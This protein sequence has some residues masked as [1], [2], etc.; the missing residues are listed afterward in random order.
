MAEVSDQVEFW[1]QKVMTRP[2]QKIA[3][4][5]HRLNTLHVQLFLKEMEPPATFLYK[6]QEISAGM[7]LS[8]WRNKFAQLKAKD[9][10]KPSDGM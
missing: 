4:E 8:N 5:R 2:W 9:L 10:S 6:V 3:F 1:S 7:H